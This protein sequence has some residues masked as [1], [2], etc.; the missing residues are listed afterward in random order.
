MIAPQIPSAWQTLSFTRRLRGATFNVAFT[1]EEGLP[2]QVVEVDGRRLD[3]GRLAAI[4]PGR[5]Y[6]VS[7][8]SPR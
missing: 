2:E 3:D 6:D 5:I 1:R 4:E 8:R 7:V